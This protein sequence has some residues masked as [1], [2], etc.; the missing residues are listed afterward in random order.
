MIYDIKFLSRNV[1][2][3]QPAVTIKLRKQLR[4][5]LRKCLEEFPDIYS[6]VIMLG[7]VEHFFTYEV[8]GDTVEAYVTPRDFAEATFN[9]AGLQWS[10]LSQREDED[11]V[12]A[13]FD[14]EKFQ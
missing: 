6:N 3:R 5:H 7:G 14:E 8:K 9:E 12:D 4:K 10:P 1:D 11:V 2:T 13:I